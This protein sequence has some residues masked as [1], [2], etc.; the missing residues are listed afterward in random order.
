MTARTGSLGAGVEVRLTRA[1]DL[2]DSE[3]ARWSELQE[4][5]PDLASGF[6]RPELALAVASVRSDVEV[7]VLHRGG[8]TLGF[9]P[10]QRGRGDVAQ[11]LTGRLSEF[12]GVVAPPGFRCDAAALVGAC[13][14]RAWHFDHAPASQSVFSDS[15]W[16]TS[17]SPYLDL[18]SGFEAYRERLRAAG[19][20]SIRQFERKARKLEREVGPLR[21]QLHTDDAAALGALFDWKTRQYERTG[22]VQ[23]FRH[24]W[25]LDLLERIQRTQGTAFAGVFS[26]L[27]A[28]DQLI[29]VHLGIRSRTALHNW[30]PAYDPAFGRYS[31][32]SVLLLSLAR[33]AADSGIQRLD[34]GKGPERY[35]QSFATDQA[36]L[37]EGAVDLRPMVA[38]LW[39]RWHLAKRRIRTSP[40]R[41]HLQPPL[42]AT[43]RLRQWWAFR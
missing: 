29:A 25:V 5:D 26:S 22:M 14:L 36:P 15:R 43:R 7:A 19:R 38:A 34:L 10:F 27:H 12:H 28:G 23:V 31:P 2:A 13:G 39:R 8:E 40:W 42:E 21:F 6:F 41:S 18:S 1:P 37:L 33:E 16:T 17:S 11:A 35:K 30:F 9:F 24:R 20:D 3:L 4:A 32:G